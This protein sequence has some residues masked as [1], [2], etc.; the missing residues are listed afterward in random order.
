MARRNLVGLQ[1]FLESSDAIM[2]RFGSVSELAIL[3]LDHAV[4][5][6][7][8]IAKRLLTFF[9]SDLESLQKPLWA[10]SF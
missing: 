4:A 10:L 5:M 6:L 8:S 2:L 3:T 9:A 7:T 1:F